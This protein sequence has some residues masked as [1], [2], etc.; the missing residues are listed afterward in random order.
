M[1]DSGRHQ[2]ILSTSK[3]K[4][5]QYTLEKPPKAAHISYRPELVGKQYGWVKIISPEKRWNQKQNHCYVLTKC[6]GCG[7]IS[8]IELNSLQRGVS[9]GCQACSQKREVPKWLLKRLEAAK[10][11]CTNP[12]DS[13]Y[14]NYGAR[15]IKFCFRTATDAGLYMIHKYGIPSRSMQIDRIDNEGNYAPGNLRF[16]TRAQNQANRR[17]TVLSEFH[18]V[19]WP[20]SE[21]V[22]RGKLIQGKSRE[23]IIQDA[24]TAVMEK[25]KNWKIISARLEFMTYEMP[26]RITVL[27]YRGGSCITAATAD[28]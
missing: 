13:E 17:N 16:S 14:R 24:E 27:P 6:T 15:G 28:L 10:Q 21:S 11:R 20:Y 8:W 19:Y 9:H 7:R 5:S 18:Q 25:R 26:D 12:R 2:T 23:Q 4:I 1:K 22:V 3:G